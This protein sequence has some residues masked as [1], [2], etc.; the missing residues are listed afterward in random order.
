MLESMLIKPLNK[1][2]EK[3]HNLFFRQIPAET[4]SWNEIVQLHVL[5]MLGIQTMTSSNCKLGN[6]MH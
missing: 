1:Q 2:S 6:T 3:L 5:R 4:L